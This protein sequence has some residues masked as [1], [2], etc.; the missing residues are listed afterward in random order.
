[1]GTGQILGFLAKG[2]PHHRPNKLS[3]SDRSALGFYLTCPQSG[4]PYL[5]CPQSGLSHR[6]LRRRSQ[7]LQ[8]PVDGSGL[9]GASGIRQ[10]PQNRTEVALCLA[11]R[12]RKRSRVSH[13][14][15]LS[16]YWFCMSRQWPV[17]FQAFLSPAKTDKCHQ[18]GSNQ[19]LQNAARRNLYPIGFGI[20]H[21]P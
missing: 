7:R 13:S 15:G 2:L 9:Q 19:E 17:S 8:W 21:S 20:S 10:R 16:G 14:P 12:W 11:V 4:L 5:T 3:A 6:L 1:M 18:Q